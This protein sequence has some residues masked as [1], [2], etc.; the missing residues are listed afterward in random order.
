MVIGRGKRGP[1]RDAEKDRRVIEMHRAG[2]SNQ[3][4]ADAMGCTRQRIQ[5][6]LRRLRQLVG[7]PPAPN[8]EQEG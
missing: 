1:L 2:R 8:T 7:A 4:I 3:E 6:R 5:M